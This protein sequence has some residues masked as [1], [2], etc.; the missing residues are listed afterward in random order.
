MNKKIS[1]MLLV[2]V[3]GA[4]L[5]T[6]C[7]A[8]KSYDS[9]PM[10]STNEALKDEMGTG[11]TQDYAVSEDAVMEGEVGFENKATSKQANQK[12][13]H[14][15]SMN[16]EVVDKLEPLIKSIQSFIDKHDGYIEDM[17]QYRSGYDPIT[18]ENLEV[19]LMRIRIPHEHYNKALQTISELG[20]VVNKSSSV[21]DVTLQYSDI[22]ST[23]K[24]YKVEQDRLLE[25]LKNDTT[26]VKDM[27][28]IEKRLSEVR[29]QLEKQESARRALESLI[30]YDT[31]ELEIRQVRR[32]SE[33]STPKTFTS[34]MKAT[35]EE[36]IDGV[37][38]F[39]Q[40]LVL[41]AVYLAIPIMILLVLL[42]IAYIPIS[43]IRKHK[44]NK[45][46][47]TGENNAD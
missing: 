45:K 33:G 10:E 46:K 4:L 3:L 15:A 38:I 39:F 35:F 11:S 30:S 13:I 27:I 37:I 24:M 9:M 34:R 36:S 18:Q 29:V 28:E 22:Q 2:L 47:D 20:T 40:T 31:I 16:V 19:V 26:D 21:E 14:R 44:K 17:E 5:I 8:S 41:I 32:A 25:M 6:G 7:G 43:K 42:A 1:R 23:L 12:L